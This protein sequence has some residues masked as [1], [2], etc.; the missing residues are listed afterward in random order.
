MR[1]N[2]LTIKLKEYYQNEFENLLFSNDPYWG[3]DEGLEKPLKTINSNQNIQ[4]IYSKKFKQRSESLQLFPESY[5]QIAYSFSVENNLQEKLQEIK[6]AFNESKINIF[7]IE[8]HENSNYEMGSNKQFGCIKNPNYF[9]VKYFHIG[10]ISQLI[11]DHELF[12][13]LLEKK[14]P[15]IE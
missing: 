7:N 15:Y 11:E 6:D 2:Y 5:L 9:Y 13:N 3:I 12:W 1:D 4:T 8:P 10:I 14:L